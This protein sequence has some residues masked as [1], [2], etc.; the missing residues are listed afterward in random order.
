MSRVLLVEDDLDIQRNLQLL[1]E[2]EGYHVSIA[3]NGLEAFKIL[4][5]EQYLPDLILLDLMMPEMNGF[6]FR[7]KQLD[8]AKF[9]HIPAVVMTAAG[10]LEE[11]KI[12]PKVSAV[13]RKPLDIDLLVSLVESFSL[14]E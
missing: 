2:S 13:I 10:I 7:D 4:E 1:F 11:N 3:S 12:R 8:S 6:E 14:K 9:R 5:H